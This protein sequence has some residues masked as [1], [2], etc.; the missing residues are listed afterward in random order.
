MMLVLAAV[1]EIQYLKLRRAAVGRFGF[2]H[3]RTWDDA[4]SAIRTRPV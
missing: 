2:V 3:A 4:L 1:P